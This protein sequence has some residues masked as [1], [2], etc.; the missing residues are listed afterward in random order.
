MLP[1]LPPAPSRDDPTNFAA[2]AEAF[3]AALSGWGDAANAL[4]Q[5][6]QLVATTGTSTT[7]LAIGTGVKT[8]TSQAGKA[9]VVGSY[10]YL[11][12]ASS[13]ANRMVGQ[14]TAYDSVTGDLAINVSATSG[15]GTFTAWVI[16]L[17]TSNATAA[18]VSVAD[19]ASKFA[20]ANVETVL[21]EI[22]DAVRS[23]GWQ[24]ADAGG[25]A[26]A[27]TASFMPVITALTHHQIVYV[28][29]AAANT[30]AAT[31]Q[32]DATTAYAI[33][34]G[35]NKDLLP[36]DI[37]GAGHLLALRRDQ[38]LGKWELLNP[39][40]GITD[41]DAP[42]IIKDFGG[43]TPPAGYFECDGSSLLRSAYPEL[44]AAIGTLHGAADALHFNIPD[45][46]GKFKRGWAHGTSNDPNASSRSAAAT[47]GATGDHVGTGQGHAVQDHAHYTLGTNTA[48]GSGPGSGVLASAANNT[49]GMTSGNI[50]TETRPINAAVMSIIKY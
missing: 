23:T 28:R 46:R 16:G 19:A 45:H 49:G 43:E 36:G 3:L 9:W 35:A 22:F 11:V 13:V 17:A 33:Y 40:R 26:N 44:F 1:T 48:T 21:A 10:V 4:E 24:S 42:G 12:A 14:I 31:F 18:E 32:A 39:A 25:T 5:S 7:S 47:G 20:G 37:A 27:I 6:L 34:K 8:I 30:G 15:T 41:S 50:A 29:A 38:T 2:M